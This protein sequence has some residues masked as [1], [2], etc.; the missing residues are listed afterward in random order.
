MPVL[1][2]EFFLRLNEN[3][4]RLLSSIQKSSL[5][6]KQIIENSLALQPDL[7][8][9]IRNEFYKIISK[10]GSGLIS[11]VYCV[12]DQINGSTYAL[13]HARA[14]FEFYRQSLLCEKN[15]SELIEKTCN[16]LK[17]AKC[18]AIENIFLLKE[19][20]AFPTLQQLLFD[21]NVTS[22][23]REKLEYSLEECSFLFEN[24]G[25]LI[26]L[27]P[28]NIAWNGLNWILIDSGPK[29]HRSDFEEVLK[30]K[31]WESYY[32]YIKENIKHGDS[33]P[34]VLSLPCE[35]EIHLGKEMIFVKD[36]LLWL[37]LDD[38]PDFDFFYVKQD[39]KVLSDEALI[40]LSLEN[41]SYEN[42]FKKYIHPLFQFLARAAWQN[43]FQ[44]ENTPKCLD[45]SWEE[46]SINESSY[47]IDINSFVSEIGGIHLGKFLKLAN[48]N[49]SFLP[50]PTLKTKS[51]NHW[52]DLL[53]PNYAHTTCDIFDNEPLEFDASSV[54]SLSRRKIEIPLGREFLYANI[55][56]I[57]EINSKR[58]ILLLPGFRAT[59]ESSF[60]LIHELKKQQINDQFI[61]AQLGVKNRDGELLVSAGCWE[62]ILIWEVFEYCFNYLNFDK[63][64][65]LAASH[66]A[67]GG[68]IASCL[69]PRINKIVLDSPLLYPLKILREISKYRKESEEEMENELKRNGI[70][71]EN[72]KMFQNPPSSLQ[73]ITM[74]PVKDN[75]ID[76]CGKMTFGKQITYNGGHASTLRHDSLKKGIPQICTDSLVEFLKQ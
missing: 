67:I 19:L 14:D 34:S 72:F 24:Y 51:Y 27:S 11:N 21:D 43:N 54:D 16:H 30:I 41:N 70:P 60:A 65:V 12:K 9:R 45:F 7:E 73:I 39:Q 26:D 1:N 53:D 58:A 44:I 74:L 2:Q 42:N 64:D 47:P 32:N 69:H 48:K 76:L 10:L 25:V 71:F 52:K 23:Q 75:F 8:I 49:Q 3:Q 36:W 55:E 35:T 37:P 59:I 17:V 20:C 40:K 38:N 68:W 66:G 33:K 57:G 13:K 18:I 31:T 62:S 15:V 56:I 63:I 4:I 50:I 46:L 61:V 28:K 29:I 22:I 6:K 5:L